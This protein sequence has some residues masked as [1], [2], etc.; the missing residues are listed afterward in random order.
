MTEILS[1]RVQKIL[2]ALASYRSEMAERGIDGSIT[3]QGCMLAIGPDENSGSPTEYFER[4]C[5]GYGP[6]GR[7]RHDK[8][9]SDCRLATQKLPGE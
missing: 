6:N 2:A 8:K 4:E 3:C 1:P 9:I 7:K 5:E